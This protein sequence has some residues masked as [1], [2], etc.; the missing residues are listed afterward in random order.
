MNPN[1]RSDESAPKK[2]DDKRPTTPGSSRDLSQHRPTRRERT[3]WRKAKN[4][5]DA[6]VKKRRDRRTQHHPGYRGHLATLLRELRLMLRRYGSVAV[7][8]ERAVSDKTRKDRGLVMTQ[9]LDD[10]YRGGHQ[11]HHLRNFRGR[12]VRAILSHWAEQ[13]LASSTTATYVSHLRTFVG[14]VNKPTLLSIVDQFC[15]DHPGFTHRRSATI[16]DKSERGANVNFEEIYR[17]ATAT[18]NEY[19]VSQLLLIAAFGLRARDAWSFRPHLS[20]GPLGGIEVNKGTKGGRPRKLPAALTPA[21]QYALERARALVPHEHGSMIPPQFARMKEWS[22][23]FYRLCRRIGLTKDQLGVTP[24]SLRHGVL[25][26]LYERLAG[27]PAPVRGGDAPPDSPDREREA[28]KIVAEAAGHSRPQVSS[29]Y[30]GSRRQSNVDA[31]PKLPDDPLPDEM[32]TT[33]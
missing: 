16:T 9:M 11:L 27:V 8:C 25:L 15:A 14:W 6:L 22:G 29:A 31:S 10:L 30:L 5:I 23:E 20:V 17:R 28:R 19:F 32:P 7:S 3:L 1:H 12:H 24:H 26:D 13:G 18:G 33:S 2:P 21:Q 4:E